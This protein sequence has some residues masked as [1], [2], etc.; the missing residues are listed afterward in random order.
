MKKSL[1][2][3]LLM[4]TAVFAGTAPMKINGVF[5]GPL[6]GG[7]PKMIE[8]YVLTDIPDLT[9]YGFGSANNGGG[10]D[11]EEF[12][13]PAGSATAGDFL[14]LA[15]ETPNFTTYFGFPPDYTSGAAG[16][17]GD[18]A[19]ELFQNGLVIDVFGDI[20]IDGTGQS[21][22]YL[23]SFVHRVP[24]TGPDGSIWTEVNWTITPPNS[25]DGCATNAT[26]NA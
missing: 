13:F 4:G 8:F 23:D 1:L 12:T 9:I 17:N 3:I 22:E 5:D 20:N 25:V 18:D 15:S 14:Y 26:C 21:W 24:N 19:V 6:S 11:G 2:V 16:V 7:V 10:T